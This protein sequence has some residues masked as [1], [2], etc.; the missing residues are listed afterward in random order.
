MQVLSLLIV[1]A[2]VVVT[3]FAP[4]GVAVEVAAAVLGHLLLQLLQAGLTRRPTPPEDD[5]DRSAAA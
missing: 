5:D 1:L 4:M 3:A 2:A